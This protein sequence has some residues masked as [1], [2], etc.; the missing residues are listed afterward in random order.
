M[1]TRFKNRR[2]LLFLAA[3]LC[4]ALPAHSSAQT[5]TT[6]HAFRLA[7]DGASPRAGLILSGHTL[8]GTTYTYSGGDGTLFGLSTN[9]SATDGTGFNIL[10]GFTTD[11][12]AYPL[13]G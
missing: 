9:G 4:C 2:L 8:Y 13:A 1:R 11:S 10:V 3:W 5:F 6:L 7:S 12:G